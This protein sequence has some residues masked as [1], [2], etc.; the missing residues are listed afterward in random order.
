MMSV[1]SEIGRLAALIQAMR[2]RYQSGVYSRAIIFS[3]RDGAGLDGQMD[4]IAERGKG[5]DSLDDVAGKVARMAGGEADAPDAWN[6]ADGGQ[7]VRRSST[8]LPGRD[9]C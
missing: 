5:V 6:L 2:S 9:S 3:T 1:E 4:V 8:S 7:Q